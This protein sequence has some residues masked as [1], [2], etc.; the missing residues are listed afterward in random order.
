MIQPYLQAEVNLSHRTMSNLPALEVAINQQVIVQLTYLTGSGSYS[1]RQVEPLALYH[2][3][4][5]GWTLVAWCRLRQDYRE[6]R[7]DRIQKLT[8]TT[9]AYPPRFFQL[10]KY[11]SR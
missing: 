9:E 10:D 11:F 1:E 6:F 2:T 4:N 7:L 5:T 8:A 3:N